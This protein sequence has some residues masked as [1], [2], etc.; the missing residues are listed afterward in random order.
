MGGGARTGRVCREPALQLR[1]APLLKRLLSGSGEAPRQPV[2]VGSRLDS[3]HLLVECRSVVDRDHLVDV[4]AGVEHRD[5][6]Q[7]LDD[8]LR[9]EE[10]LAL[11]GE[12]LRSKHT[13]G[14]AAGPASLP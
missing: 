6:H 10:V 3:L 7:P 11:L 14:P 13:A 1:V 4:V 2:P 12:T 9:L 5:A 8:E